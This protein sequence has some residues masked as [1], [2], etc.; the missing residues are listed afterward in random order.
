MRCRYLEGGSRKWTATFDAFREVAPNVSF[1]MR[2]YAKQ[3]RPNS[4]RVEFRARTGASR[5][6][7]GIFRT[8]SAVADV[9]SFVLSD[10]KA[11]PENFT[12]AP[13]PPFSG[14]A[15]FQRTPESVFAWDGDLSIQFPGA[16]PLAL[17]GPEFNTSYCALRSC[18]SQD[19]TTFP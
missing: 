7:V 10:P 16:A 3:L 2:R 15:T 4:R 1:T 14:T 8:V 6:P 11:A 12:L 19:S 17:A 9:S 18:V 13:P 5:G